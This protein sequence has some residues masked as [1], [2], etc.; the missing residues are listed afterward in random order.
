MRYS[1]QCWTRVTSVASVVTRVSVFFFAVGFVGMINARAADFDPLGTRESVSTSTAKAMLGPDTSQA[2][3]AT[4]TISGPV[5]LAMVAEL[6][7]CNNAQTRQVWANVKIQAAQVGIAKSAYLPSVEVTGSR[8]KGHYDSTV[9]DAPQLDYQMHSTARDVALNL[10]WTLF[11]FGLRSANLESARQL[12]T[13]ANSTQ[14]ATLQTVFATAAQAYYDL[15]SA[16]GALDASKE[17]ELS[18][19]GSFEAA[20][21]KY[22]AGVGALADKLQAQTDYAQARL[23]RAKAERDV[24]STHGTLAVAMGL[25]ANATFD[26][27]P[28]STSLAGTEFV[29]SVDALIELAKHQHPTLLAA[30][31]QVKAAEASIAAAKA[32][33]LPTLSLVG[34]IDRNEQPGQYSFDTTTNT[35]TIGLQLK[36]PLFEGLGRLYRVQQAKAEFESKSADLANAEQQNSLDVWKN[37]Q[38]LNT[39]TENLKTTDELVQSAS[40]SFNVAQGRYKSGVGNIIELLNAQTSLA[41]ARQQ[42]IQTLSNWRSARIK[43]AASLGQLGMWAVR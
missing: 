16:E 37:Y 25:P 31:A 20:D 22:K 28:T 13:A 14:D 30:Q 18:A 6:A 21:A 17:A 40:L 1:S 34:N 35:K 9:K 19:K 11:D 39:E 4:T 12:L 3:C 26:L 43:L 32:E 33:G 5:D 23:N 38:A 29:Q 36:I 8:S 27:V 7:L 2:P 41:N 10:S 42:K 15:Q 24:K